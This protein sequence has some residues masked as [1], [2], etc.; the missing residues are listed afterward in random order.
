MRTI[1]ARMKS[2]Y[3]SSR[4][5]AE[6]RKIEWHFTFEQWCAW[7]RSELGADWMSLRGCKKGQYVMARKLDK[8]HYVKGNVDCILAEQNHIDY[9][10]R[11]TIRPKYVPPLPDETVIAI[12]KEPGTPTRLSKKYGVT[13]LQV[14]CIKTKRYY[15][16]ITD[17]IDEG[18]TVSKPDET[19]KRTKK[20]LQISDEAWLLSL[21]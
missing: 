2:A 7:W 12:Y 11:R 14:Y 15:K 6:L 13:K 3:R 4:G 17:E 21:R 5:N 18:K 16:K 20:T 1:E 19:K 9:N 10:T 8:G